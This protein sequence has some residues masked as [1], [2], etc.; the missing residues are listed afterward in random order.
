MFLPIPGSL[1][2]LDI[3]VVHVVPHPVADRRFLEQ[4][5]VPAEVV[6]ASSQLGRD[7]LAATGVDVRILGVVVTGIL[8]RE[9][10]TDGLDHLYGVVVR[11]SDC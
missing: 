9:T 6:L 3:V 5:G 11:T 7:C 8:R 10:V 1:A 2:I 4:S